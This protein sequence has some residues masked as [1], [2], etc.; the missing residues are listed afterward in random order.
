MLLKTHVVA[1]G[2]LLICAGCV[3][4]RVEAHVA[5]PLSAD[6][7][8]EVDMSAPGTTLMAD[9]SSDNNDEDPSAPVLD[10]E[11]VMNR[12][13]LLPLDEG[14]DLTGDTQ[15]N[16]ALS[17]LFSDPVVGRALGGDPNEFI[18]RTVRRGEMLLLMDFRNL[19]DYENDPTFDVDIF[20][21]R[22]ADGRRRNNFEGTAEFNVSCSSVTAAQEPESRFLNVML[23][24]GELAGHGGQ[25][26][27]LVSF[28]DTEVLLRN[29]EL[30]GALSLDGQRITDGMIGGAVTYDDLEEVVVNDPEIGP[31]F[32]RVMLA[33]IR[34]KL[35][36]DLD[37]DGLADAM[38]AAFK[39]EA[40][41]AVVLLEQGCVP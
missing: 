15:P 39:F 16:N 18:A 30:R 6:L 14:F 25:F 35:D 3:N 31:D 29:A 10:P 41:R 4:D 26:R 34:Q 13:E 9:A 32:A 8:P 36:V 33:F 21:G 22:D 7:V 1:F 37:A 23:M 27:F 19:N 20:L 40:V 12:V 2:W 17:L 28:S 24:D 38:S 11:F 5:E